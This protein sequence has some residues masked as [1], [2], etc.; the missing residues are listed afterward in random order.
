MASV[1]TARA[2]LTETTVLGL[3]TLYDIIHI[4]DEEEL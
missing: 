1:L 4:K 2:V 3:T